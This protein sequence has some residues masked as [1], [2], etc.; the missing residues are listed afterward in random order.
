MRNPPERQPLPTVLQISTGAVLTNQSS[1]LR[2]RLSE[3]VGSRCVYETLDDPFTVIDTAGGW[4]QFRAGTIARQARSRPERTHPGPATH[5]LVGN[6]EAAARAAAAAA[7][8]C[9][10]QQGQSDRALPG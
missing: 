6:A 10:G 9:S 2:Q 4:Y 1:S 3:I 8:S 5:R 7:D